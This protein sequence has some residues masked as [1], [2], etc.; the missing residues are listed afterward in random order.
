MAAF[1]LALA[2]AIGLTAAEISILRRLSSPARIQDFIF[3]M[4]PNFEGQGDT[5]NSVRVA[6]RENTCHCIEAAFIAACA[7][8]LHGEPSLLMDFQANGDHDHVV[9]LFKRDGHWGA[10][11]KSNTIWLRWRDPVYQSPRELA[12]SYFHEY[13]NGKKKTLRRVSKPFNIG[14]F[15]AQDWITSETPCWAIAGELDTSPHIEL[16]S[17]R[18]ARQLKQ[19]DPFEIGA[20]KL[21]EVPVPPKGKLT[22]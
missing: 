15:R 8:M 9:A 20:G 4:P 13:V 12:M 18:L 10:I 22:T 16:V 5:C 14:A 1:D 2:R 21:R 17:A 19:R 11:S 3:A 7:L 6:L